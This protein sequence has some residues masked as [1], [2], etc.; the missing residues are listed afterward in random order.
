MI[1]EESGFS[2]LHFVNVSTIIKHPQDI[3]NENEVEVDDLS[4][5]QISIKKVRDVK[6]QPIL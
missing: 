4:F 1:R 6:V 5:P 2:D 3:T